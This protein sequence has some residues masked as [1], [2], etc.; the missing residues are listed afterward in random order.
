MLSILCHGRYEVFKASVHGTA[1]GLAALCAVYNFAAW[2]ARRQRHS[3]INAALYTTLTAWEIRHV[4]HH[5]NCQVVK[6]KQ[7]DAK[8]AA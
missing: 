1:V 7:T 6:A 3:W 5:L 8:Q 2:L 4:Q